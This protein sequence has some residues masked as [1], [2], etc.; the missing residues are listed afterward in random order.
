M[1]IT[2]PFAGANIKVPGAYSKLS[3]S[4]VGSLPLTPTGIVGIIGEASKGAPGSDTANGG[5][6][7]FDSAT[8]ADLINYFGDGPI[9]DGARALVNAS[10]DSRILQ[11]ASKILVYKTNNST[12]ASLIINQNISNPY[13][14]INSRNWGVNENL[15][16]VTITEDTAEAF[17]LQFG[18]DYTTTPGSDLTLR[19]N[20]GT[21]V[22]ITAANCTTVGNT[23]TELNTK[24]NTALG[25]VAI[26]YAS[27]ATNRITIN[28][29]ITGT[30]AKRP[31]MGISLELIAS[32]EWVDIGVTV[33][34]QGVAIVAGSGVTG[35]T[36]A[37]PTRTIVVNRQQDQITET[38]A[39]T[40]GELGGKIY[41]EIGCNAATSALLTISSTTLSVV[42]TG[43]GASSISLNLANFATLADLAQYINAQTGYQ[44]SIPSNIN[45]GL[46]PTVLD[47]VTSVGIDASTTDIK[48][49]QIKADSYEVQKWFD[50]NSSLT[51]LSRTL[52]IGLPDVIA[53]TYLAGGTRGSSTTSSFNNGFTAFQGKRVNIIVPL[54]SQD[55]SDDIVESP[56]YT[57]ASSS[58]DIESVL[59]QAREHCKLMSNVVNRSERNAYLGYRETFQ[60]C[61]NES[62]IINS[63]FCSLL[64]QDIQLIG[65]DGA[66]FWGR[67]HLA[68][69]LLAGLQ[70]GAEIGLPATF[71][72]VA[73]NGI[74]HVKK[75]G[76]APL[77]TELFDPNN[78]AHKNLAIEDGLLIFEAPS[79]GGIRV[80]LQNSTYQNDANFVFNRPSVLAAAHY[81][82]YNLRNQLEVLF[83]GD[84]VRTGTAESIRNAT[85][86]VMKQ[87]L[88]AEII[89]GDDT[90][91]G[92]GYKNLAVHVNGNVAT[93]DICITPVQGVDFV[94][95]RITLDNIRQSA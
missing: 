91:A 59:I 57:D 37:N 50:N 34:Q 55:A 73:V 46:P 94:L 93:I 33:P 58:Y 26:A 7:E 39:N 80:V 69:C 89:V 31:G 5:I 78:P 76:V 61:R 42:A 28:L 67:P 8:L 60:N 71:K 43:M 11:G 35:L 2:I 3:T 13:A 20:G 30:G 24:L 77:T 86:A 95:A 44:C 45:S 47:R 14:T 29:G 56:G 81:V 90:N 1:A 6:K 83:V 51:S 82:A 62:K 72:Y 52:Y 54:I 22:T 25:T 79:S 36:A 68:A 48:P 63:E 27:N 74:R 16:N 4:L 10:N 15:I 21:V 18:A 19:V 85:I 40:T 64:F 49:G 17:S 41:M 38:T 9:V 92:L 12:A 87:F 23:V 84:K 66:L 88:D 32:S 53:L 75:Q 70:A 65:T